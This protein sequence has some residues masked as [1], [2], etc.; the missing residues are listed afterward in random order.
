[1]PCVFKFTASQ[2]SV[3]LTADGVKYA[4]CQFYSGE[5]FTT[6]SSL[7]CTVNNNLKSSIKAL[8]RLLYQLHSML[9]EQGHQLIWKI[10]NVL[11]LV[12]IR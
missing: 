7:K 5:E 6:F 11:L 12:S 4:T 9:V 1:M 2:K 10:L 8:V 3:D